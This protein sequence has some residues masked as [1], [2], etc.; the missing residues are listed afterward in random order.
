M[1]LM[2][3]V[4]YLIFSFLLSTLLWSCQGNEPGKSGKSVDAIRLDEG[5][6]NADLIRNPVSADG[7]VDSTEV[8]R[9]VF[10]ETIH[11]FGAV[12]AGAV[13][14]HEFEF[15]NVGSVPLIISDARSTCGCTVPEWPKSPI[16]PGQKGTILVKF[17]TKNKEGVQ[18][19]PVTI[20]ANT[21]PANTQIF[22][23]GEVDLVR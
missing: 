9:I 2:T 3:S 17:D 13:V 19:K 12:D 15:T 6:S 21:F 22:L 20:T 16:A 5:T 10:D 1:R 14:S 4:G 7:S 23:K 11:D 8:A 18:Q